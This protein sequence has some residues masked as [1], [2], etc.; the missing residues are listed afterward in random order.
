MSVPDAPSFDDF[1]HRQE[2]NRQQST[3][4]FDGKLAYNGA[5]SHAHLADVVTD[6]PQ[7]FDAPGSSSGPRGHSAQ[8][9]ASLRQDSGRKESLP[10]ASTLI[11]TAK[12]Q[13]DRQTIGDIMFGGGRQ[14]YYQEH[15]DPARQIAPANWTSTQEQF[16]AVASPYTQTQ[17][18]FVSHSP[19]PESGE[20][21]SNQSTPY[22]STFQDPTV[23]NGWAYGQENGGGSA[24]V[25]YDWSGEASGQMEGMLG[26]EGQL[27]EL[28]RM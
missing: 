23:N 24:D 22:T 25:S 10:F 18:T 11:S 9:V 8:R 21:M 3:D 1:F 15:D 5:Y 13:Q 27:S 14:P 6:E 19:R 26:V 28:E 4:S 17:P 2:A 20:F 16:P 7:S 12:P